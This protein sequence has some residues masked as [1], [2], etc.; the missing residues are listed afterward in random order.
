MNISDDPLINKDAKFLDAFQNAFEAN[1][2][3]VV[4][5][6]HFTKLKAAFYEAR[7]SVKKRISPFKSKIRE[8]AELIVLYALM[9]Q[10]GPCNVH[11]ITY[12]ITCM[13]CTNSN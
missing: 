8:K 6:P 3:S 13:G 12:S 9:E 10:K 11:R 4:F 7:R 1:E 2:T 5:K